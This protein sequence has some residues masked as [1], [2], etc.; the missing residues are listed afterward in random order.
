MTSKAWMKAT[1]DQRLEMLKQDLQD[2]SE[3]QNLLAEKVVAD[4]ERRLVALEAK[5]RT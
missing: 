3:K 1:T 4:I 2:L 5:G